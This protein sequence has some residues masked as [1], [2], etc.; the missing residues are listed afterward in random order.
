MQLSWMKLFEPLNRDLSGFK[1]KHTNPQIL[2]YKKTHTYTYIYIYLY[3]IVSLTMCMYVCVREREF[4][5]PKETK[6]IKGY[7]HVE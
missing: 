7:S 2:V 5:T 3:N 4:S 6:E 1:P